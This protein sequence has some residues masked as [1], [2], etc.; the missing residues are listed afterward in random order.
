MSDPLQVYRTTN[1][2]VFGLTT[3]LSGHAVERLARLAVNDA[4]ARGHR[5][6]VCAIIALLWVLVASTI[7]SLNASQDSFFLTCV[8]VGALSHDTGYRVRR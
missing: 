5:L 1:L 2:A 7:A 8:F 6:A 3:Y 4:V